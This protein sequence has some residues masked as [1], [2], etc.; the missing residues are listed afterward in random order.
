MISGISNLQA[1]EGINRLNTEH[2]AQH[3]GRQGAPVSRDSVDI[4]PAARM[5][6]AEAEQ[7][8]Q[9]V[10]QEIKATASEALSVHQGLDYN[11]VMALLGDI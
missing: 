1:H 9:D 6:D 11:R 4:N 7:T 8:L 5:T 2:A 3:N 10:S